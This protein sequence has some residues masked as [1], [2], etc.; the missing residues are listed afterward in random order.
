[1][2]RDGYNHHPSEI[3]V[4]I[5]PQEIVPCDIG[6]S[7]SSE[8]EDFLFAPSQLNKLSKAE[9]VKL[10]NGKIGTNHLNSEQNSHVQEIISEFS[11]LFLLPGNDLPGTTLV[12]YKIRAT[13]D[14]PVTNKQYRY[15]PAHK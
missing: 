6:L 5:S 12:Q 7:E 14:I 8:P 3:C 15:P 13:D 10:I 2:S 4:Q 9:R 11:N 1:M